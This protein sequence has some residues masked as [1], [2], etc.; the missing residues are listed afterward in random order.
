[1][2]VDTKGTSMAKWDLGPSIKSR[3]RYR[4]LQR[5]GKG[6]SARMPARGETIRKGRYK[7]LTRA[8]LE[9][10]ADEIGIQGGSSMDRAELIDALRNH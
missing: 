10:R 9:H 6:M 4:A 7:S 2:V 8:E 1:V 5:Q 3:E